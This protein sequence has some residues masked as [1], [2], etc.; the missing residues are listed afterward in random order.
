[1]MAVLLTC[2]AA[3]GCSDA[4]AP[5]HETLL[6]TMA[7]S[8]V[9][10]TRSSAADV[11][12]GTF[13]VEVTLDNPS[14]STLRIFSCSPALERETPSGWQVALEPFCSLSAPGYFELP[15]GGQKRSSTRVMGALA[16]PGG[17][18]FLGH[19]LAGHYRLVYRY[20]VAG[21][22]GPLDEARS[23]PFDVVTE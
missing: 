3:S 21:A 20:S 1:M 23:A 16:G 12:W 19:T 5:R 8:S 2:I 13:P 6:V 17:P 10:A 7:A 18:E 15:P 9:T 22:E 4:T 11:V 14:A